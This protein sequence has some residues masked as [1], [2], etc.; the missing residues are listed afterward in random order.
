MLVSDCE[1]LL[2]VAKSLQGQQGQFLAAIKDED[3]R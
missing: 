2:S 1:I 3:S